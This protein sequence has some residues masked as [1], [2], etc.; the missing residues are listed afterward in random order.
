MGLVRKNSMLNDECV[1]MR[2]QLEQAENI[3]GA[4]KGVPSGAG[5][6]VITSKKVKK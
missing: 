2:L 6:P 3:Y 4:G 5:V 1:A